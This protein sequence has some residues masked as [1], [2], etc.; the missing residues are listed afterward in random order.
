MA[1]L[2]PG[3]AINASAQIAK[4]GTTDILIRWAV[5]AVSN[6]F[7]VAALLASRRWHNAHAKRAFYEG[8]MQLARNE[9][10]YSSPENAV[11]Q[12]HEAA[13]VR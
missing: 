2:S 10:E 8:A 6:I 12:P 5:V 4:I 13:R 3:T 11:R 9:D 1:G 7:E